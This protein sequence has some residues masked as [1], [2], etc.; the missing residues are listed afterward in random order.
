M[1]DNLPE[2][3]YREFCSA[4]GLSY[5]SDETPSFHNLPTEQRYAWER[6]AALA[7][8]ELGLQFRRDMRAA[9]EEH[10]A[11]QAIANLLEAA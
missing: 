8:N 4:A 1:G 5:G 3:L 9:V 11:E 2:Q 10:G 7:R 6:A